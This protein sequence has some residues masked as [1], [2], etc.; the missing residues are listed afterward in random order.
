MPD[1]RRYYVHSDD[2]CRFESMTKEQILAAITQAVEGHSIA[3]VDTGFVQVL[4]E[5]NHGAGLKFWIGSTAEYNALQSID[6]DCFYIL[7]DDTELEDMES[8][9][10]SFRAD[11]AEMG[12]TVAQHTV[13]IQGLTNTV[14]AHSEYFYDIFDRKELV[15]FDQDISYDAAM[16][17]PVLLNYIHGNPPSIDPVYLKDFSLVRVKINSGE[18]ICTVSKNGNA[19][20]ENFVYVKGCAP[21]QLQYHDPAQGSLFGTATTVVAYICLKV[22][23]TTNSI[24]A[25]TSVIATSE[26]TAFKLTVTKM[27]GVM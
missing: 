27:I 7:T 14:V 1:E 9:I 22:D 24:V 4:K 16:S 26:N 21:I 10:E 25:N 13:A 12:E 15:F 8:D 19:G 5:Q 6:Q 17:N 18:I 2:N 3:D 11:I 23:V 20:E